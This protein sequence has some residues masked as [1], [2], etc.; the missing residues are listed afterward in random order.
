MS[1]CPN[2]KMSLLSLKVV[3]INSDP[4]T[5]ECERCTAPSDNSIDEIIEVYL[6]GKT[7]KHKPRKTI[8]SLGTRYRQRRQTSNTTERDNKHHKNQ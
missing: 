1:N 3:G 5:G 2:C 4:Y 6:G 7:H 8:R